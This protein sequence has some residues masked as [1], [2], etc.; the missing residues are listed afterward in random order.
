MERD[1]NQGRVVK[2]AL[3]LTIRVLS[4]PTQDLCSRLAGKSISGQVTVKNNDTWE[5]SNRSM[6]DLG[7]GALKCNLPQ[8]IYLNLKGA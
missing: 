4:L 3:T 8:I 5:A 6:A 2:L 7:A 1:Q